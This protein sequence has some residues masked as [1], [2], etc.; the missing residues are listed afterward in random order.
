MYIHTASYVKASKTDKS[1]PVRKS[2]L[3]RIIT[4]ASYGA[5]FCT[6]ILIGIKI[7]KY[8]KG[9]TIIIGYYKSG[10]ILQRKKK[11]LKH[12]DKAQSCKAYIL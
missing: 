8:N 7:L 4:F 5:S 1:A 12:N 9:R 6:T 2:V 3:L 11:S 10:T